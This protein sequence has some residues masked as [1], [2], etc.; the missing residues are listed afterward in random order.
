[1]SLNTTYMLITPELVPLAQITSPNHK[2]PP[3]TSMRLIDNPKYSLPKT[4]LLVS[5]TTLLRVQQFCI[6][7]CPDQMPWSL[8]QLFFLSCATSNPA[9]NSFDFTFKIDPNPTTFHYNHADSVISHLDYHQDPPLG[10][11]VSYH[12][13]LHMAARAYHLPAAS[14]KWLPLSPRKIQGPCFTHEVLT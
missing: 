6:P 13:I 7:I 10:H 3:C 14:L 1:M 2:L 5:L 9:E 4:K 12:S 11:P 8:P